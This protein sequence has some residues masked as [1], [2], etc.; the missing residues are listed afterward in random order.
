M[1][2]SLNR[3]LKPKVQN[4]LTFWSEKNNLG[5]VGANFDSNYLSHFW[6]NFQNSCAYH[7]ATFVIWSSGS[8]QNVELW[9]TL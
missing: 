5:V 1:K 8:R 7:L 9:D 4:K 2:A 6:I 3:P